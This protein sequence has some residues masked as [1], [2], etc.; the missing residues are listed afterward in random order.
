MPI[1]LRPM[2]TSI[3]PFSRVSR[4]GWLRALCWVCL[5]VPAP[6]CAQ[7][8]TI[9]ADVA[10]TGGS[11]DAA[12][13][14]SLNLPVRQAAGL[15]GDQVAAWAQID[16]DRLNAV[17]RAKGFYSASVHLTVDRAAAL[18]PNTDTDGLRLIFDPVTGPL[19]RIRS[20]RMVD[21]RNGEPRALAPGEAEL[22]DG[23]RGEPASADVLARFEATWLQRQREAG[24]AFAW[25]ARR[26]ILPD[27]S[28][29]TVEAT[30]AV[31]QGPEVRFGRIQFTGLRRISPQ[32]LEP[33]A[34]FR[35]GDPY[36]PAQVDLLR[37]NLRSLP[38]FQWV[39]VEP[40]TSL[41]A[42]GLL[43]LRV[44]VVEKPPE[45]QR[46]ML[47]GSIGIAV[48]GLAAVLL[49]LAELATAGAGPSW[50][51]HRSKITVGIWI[52][53]ATSALLALQRLLYLGDL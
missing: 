51:R 11:I 34:P 49:A 32:S 2:T 33:Y 52:L 10:P 7:E 5:I 39:R 35:V 26:D 4:F 15:R 48:L 37:T 3:A 19:Y 16:R 6:L 18:K 23:L 50:Q 17:L 44:T 27:A 36:R 38:F 14:D 43:P 8:V 30:L 29:R 41:D 24:R 13:Q 45:A 46:L 40:A 25:V 1:T 31:N 53:V 22:L 47:S 42:L 21:A 20:V 12:L 28:S 9:R